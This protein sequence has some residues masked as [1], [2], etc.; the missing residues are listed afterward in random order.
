MV[1][2]IGIHRL[3][4]RMR[5]GQHGHDR[6][7]WVHSAIRSRS[8]GMRDQFWPRLQHESPSVDWY[9]A[10][11]VSPSANVRTRLHSMPRLPTGIR[12]CTASADAAVNRRT[13]GLLRRTRC[14]AAVR[15]SWESRLKQ[16]RR[17][18]PRPD[19]SAVGGGTV[20]FRQRPFYVLVRRRRSWQ[21]RIHSSAGLT[22]PHWL[23]SERFLPSRLML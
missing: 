13:T 10:D 5:W 2:R 3:L 11:C 16:T 8:R 4:R 19:N 14:A 9:I 15:R 21:R 18:M 6:R 1:R 7:E 17:D 12:R 22:L 23:L 20:T